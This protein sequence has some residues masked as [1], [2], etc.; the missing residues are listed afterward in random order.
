MTSMSLNR[1]AM[2]V[3]MSVSKAISQ[4]ASGSIEG[5]GGPGPHPYVPDRWSGQ[6]EAPGERGQVALRCRLFANDGYRLAL[7][8]HPSPCKASTP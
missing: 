3:T 5:S 1:G 8:S 4:P 6:A 7:A 2:A